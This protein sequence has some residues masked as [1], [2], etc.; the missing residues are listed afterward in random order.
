MCGI[1]CDCEQLSSQQQQ[2]EEVNLGII[3]EQTMFIGQ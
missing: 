2:Q 1:N 3:K